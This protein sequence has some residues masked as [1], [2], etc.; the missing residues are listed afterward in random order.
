[1]T[2]EI[3]EIPQ[4]GVASPETEIHTIDG[5]D[6]VYYAGEPI[7]PV[8]RKKSIDNAWC[9]PEPGYQYGRCK[10]ITRQGQRCK[11]AV[12]AG[13]PVCHYHGAGRPTKP[14]G[15][16]PS[17][18]TKHLPTSLVQKYEEFLTD[19]DIVSCRG[20]LAL[21]DSRIAE[22]LTRLEDSLGDASWVKVRHALSVLKK[23]LI[24][25]NS[26]IDAEGLL[27]EAL[28][29]NSTESEIW[30][31]IVG[32]VDSRRKLSETEMRRIEKAQHYLDIQQANALVSFLMDTVKDN[33]T[34][35][36]AIRAI[37]DK[38]KKLSTG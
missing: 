11:N 29:S 15:R 5:Q 26:I 23:S 24:K 33:V 37:S 31:S 35:P 3:I 30:K 20:E 2:N 17:K 6:I 8:G 27:E 34:D 21:M 14:G 22:L 38:F 28:E 7:V 19:P 4:D 36:V 1:M 18:Y 16:P 12:R 32:L 13:W 9:H 10:M 25:S